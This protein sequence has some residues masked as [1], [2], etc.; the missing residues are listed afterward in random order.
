[1]RTKNN[2]E[3]VVSIS[4][5]NKYRPCWVK[6]PSLTDG[7]C[8]HCMERRTLIKVIHK[9]FKETNPE[10]EY[11]ERE[12]NKGWHLDLWTK[13][14]AKYPSLEMLLKKFDP[15]HEHTLRTDAKL[16]KDFEATLKNLTSLERHFRLA[17]AF[18]KRNR[19][20]SKDFNKALGKQWVRITN[21][22]K[23]PLVIGL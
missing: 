7:L 20:I 3:G 8:H 6:N 11:K 10:Y 17:D 18:K 22:A 16:R 14:S 5:F 1:M 2:P 21:D 13:N 9:H 12:E 15:F 4:T 23:N 19:A